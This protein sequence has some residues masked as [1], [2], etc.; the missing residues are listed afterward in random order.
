MSPRQMFL[1]AQSGTA[2]GAPAPTSKRG[3]KVLAVFVGILVL[4]GAAGVAFRNSAFVE[5]FTGKGY[6]TNPLPVHSI[7]MPEIGGVEYTYT[8]QSVAIT[9]GLP[10]NYWSTERD[11]VNFTTKSAT[12]T[13]DEAKASIIGESIGTPQATAPP[14]QVMIDENSSYSPGATPSDPWIKKPHAPGWTTAQLLSRNEVHM[15]QDVID[16][17]LRAQHPDSVVDEVRNDVPVTTY[18]Y[19]FTFGKFYESAPRLYDMMR[20]LNGNAADDAMVTVTISLDAD[21]MIRYLDVDLDYHAVLEHRASIDVGVHYPYRVTID[22]ISTAVT[23]Q[24][25]LPTNVVDDTT[26]TTTVAP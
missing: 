24:I 3:R 7:T 9:D 13:Y 18:T 15:Y 19:S 25:A 6:D 5:R 20:M 17:T 1:A 16:P 23:P 14:D 8:S 10:T 21:W 4:A 26:T 11:E 22:V 2:E 12:L